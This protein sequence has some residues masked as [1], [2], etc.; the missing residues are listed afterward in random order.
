MLPALMDDIRN[1]LPWNRKYGY[2]SFV[3]VENE[4]RGKVRFK[5]IIQLTSHR[6]EEHMILCA[7]WN[8]FIC[9]S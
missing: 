3:Y 9:G 7:L 1:S 4:H 2:I 8:S 6:L 5:T